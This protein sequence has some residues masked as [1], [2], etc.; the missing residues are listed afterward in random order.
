MWGDV[1]APL[2]KEVDRFVE[3]FLEIGAPRKEE[4][5]EKISKAGVDETLL[6]YL[7]K[8][9]SGM[10]VYIFCSY[11]L[12]MRGIDPQVIKDKVCLHPLFSW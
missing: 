4:G 8:Q 1:V 5:S 3:P 9:T 10:F 7:V 2:R 11:P 12:L 6:D